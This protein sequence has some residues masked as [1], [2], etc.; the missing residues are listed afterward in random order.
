MGHPDPGF[1]FGFGFVFQ[2]HI[3]QRRSKLQNSALEV[4]CSIIRALFFV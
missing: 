2:L 3:A 1:G 4:Q